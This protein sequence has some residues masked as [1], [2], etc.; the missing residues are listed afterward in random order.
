MLSEPKHTGVHANQK[1]CAESLAQVDSWIIGSGLTSRTARAQYEGRNNQHSCRNPNP[2]EF[3]SDNG[4]PATREKSS[5]NGRDS[6]RSPRKQVT[7]T[8]ER[9]QARDAESSI[10]HACCRR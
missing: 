3:A 9:R 4:R 8:V 10:R 2:E 6:N 7:M 1:Q 5:P